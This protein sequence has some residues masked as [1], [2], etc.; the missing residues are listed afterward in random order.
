M[1]S[2]TEPLLDPDAAL[3]QVRA[4]QG[5]IDRM[6]ARTRTMSLRM[7]E[8]RVTASDPRHLVE[9]TINSS[10]ALLDIR[11]GPRLPQY[12]PVHVARIV[13]ATVQTARRQA[14]RLTREIIDETVGPDSTAAR[15]MIISTA[16][17]LGE[18]A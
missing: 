5:E 4:W 18:P 3:D 16:E 2:N 6:L 15:E 14:L 11:F 17:S 10:G 1:A 12:D 8:L 13:M 9:V 7:R